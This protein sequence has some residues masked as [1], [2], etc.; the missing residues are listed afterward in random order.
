MME[1]DD[2]NM[3]QLADG[4]TRNGRGEILPPGLR[5]QR[6]DRNPL[7]SLLIKRVKIR[8]GVKEWS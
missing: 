6:K 4:K 3:G 2:A 7:V 1:G 8:N 5:R